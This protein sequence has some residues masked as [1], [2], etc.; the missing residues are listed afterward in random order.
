METSQARV[1]ISPVHDSLSASS[2][3]LLS[4]TVHRREDKQEPLWQAHDAKNQTMKETMT[5]FYS[6]PS[7]DRVVPSGIS[8]A[9]T[10]SCLVCATSG[11]HV[12]TAQ[13]SASSKHL[14]GEHGGGCLMGSEAEDRR[15]HAPNDEVQFRTSKGA[16]DAIVET[17][18]NKALASETY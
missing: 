18:A 14:R 6:L 5:S 7:F 3:A 13:I 2:R 17:H 8:V 1:G 9:S 12:L 15:T 4:S 11:W 16:C 10:L